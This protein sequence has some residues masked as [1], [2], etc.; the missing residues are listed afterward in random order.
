MA[1]I[2]GAEG[3]KVATYGADVGST[4]I[5]APVVED[6]PSPSD[7]EWA[8]FLPHYGHSPRAPSLNHANLGG[9]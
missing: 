6:R 3:R 4:P 5:S 9:N 1:V 2:V 7:R 8:G